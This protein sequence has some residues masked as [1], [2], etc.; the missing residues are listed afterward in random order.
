MK[1]IKMLLT[2]VTVFGISA[3]NGAVAMETHSAKKI[4]VLQNQLLKSNWEQRW[5]RERPQDCYCVYIN[6]VRY[7]FLL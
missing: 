5:C 1:K 3:F 6:N 2:A 7:C 4:E